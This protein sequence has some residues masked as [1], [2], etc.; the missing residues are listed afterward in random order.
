MTLLQRKEKVVSEAQMRHKRVIVFKYYCRFRDEFYKVYVVG[1]SSQ[2]R[3]YLKKIAY[4]VKFAGRFTLPAIKVK[5]MCEIGNKII[6]K[7]TFI[8][9]MKF[10]CEYGCL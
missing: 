8:L 7:D 6:G 4:T 2:A 10:D 9:D 5:E 1:K 3:K